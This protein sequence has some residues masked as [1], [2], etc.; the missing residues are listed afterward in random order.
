MGTDCYD[1]ERGQH[2]IRCR[3]KR[4][5]PNKY[6]RIRCHIGCSHFIKKRAVFD[7]YLVSA[8]VMKSP[9]KA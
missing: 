4:D 3:E 1:E 5:A 7:S 2:L 6:A 9:E 8:Q